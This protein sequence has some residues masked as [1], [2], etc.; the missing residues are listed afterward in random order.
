[1][2]FAAVPDLTVLVATPYPPL[3]KW[4]F[5]RLRSSIGNGTECVVPLW[6]KAALSRCYIAHD[7]GHRRFLIKLSLRASNASTTNKTHHQG[8]HNLRHSFLQISSSPCSA[9]SSSSPS[10]MSSTS[11]STST[12]SPSPS[13][14]L[15]SPM[16]LPP[17]LV[18]LALPSTPTS[19]SN[20]LTSTTWPGLKSQYGTSQKPPPSQCAPGSG[21][22]DD[23]SSP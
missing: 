9:P 5:V 14:G 10:A 23:P 16:Q 22:G 20:G 13:G 21:G 11:A 2:A 15:C 8:D 12:T 3:R 19:A 4:T 18:A 6:L 1:M 17:L 7:I